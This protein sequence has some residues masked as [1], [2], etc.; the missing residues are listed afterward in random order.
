M[1]DCKNTAVGKVSSGWGEDDS[2]TPQKG[3]MYPGRNSY[4]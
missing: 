1:W 4:A 2:V 3:Y